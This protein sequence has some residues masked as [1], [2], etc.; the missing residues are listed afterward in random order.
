[1]EEMIFPIQRIQTDRGSEFF[2]Y[3]VQVRFMEYGIKFR[4]IRPGAP[5]LNGKVERS[6]KTDKI[7]FYAMQNLDAPELEDRL[8]EWQFHYNR[9]RP[10]GAFRR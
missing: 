4:P 5:H 3:A 6:Q 9:R 8:A 2:A 10:H 1:M 7:E